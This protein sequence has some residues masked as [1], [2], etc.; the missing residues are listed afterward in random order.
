M[1]DDAWADENMRCFGMLI[2]GRAQATG[3]KQRGSDVSV[4]IVPNSHHDLVRFALPEYALCAGWRLLF[5]TNIP[6]DEGGADF[7]TGA[8]YDVTGRSVVAFQLKAA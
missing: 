4:L 7:A 3:I 1:S 6:E 2:D 8:V 5:D